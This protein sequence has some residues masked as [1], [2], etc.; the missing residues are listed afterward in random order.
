MAVMHERYAP[1][2]D[3]G[4]DMLRH[5]GEEGGVV[6]QRAHRADRRCR[7][8]RPRPRGRLLFHQR[9]PASIPEQ[10]YRALRDHFRQ[11]APYVLNP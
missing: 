11:H 1:G 7:D 8:T 10:R 9:N 2:A 5:D 3:T 4:A 6:V